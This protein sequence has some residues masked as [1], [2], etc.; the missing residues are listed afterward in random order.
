M[1]VHSF[2]FYLVPR[3]T[4]GVFFFLLLTSKGVI[5]VLSFLRKK[6]E[7]KPTSSSNCQK[8]VFV[9]SVCFLFCPC[10]LILDRVFYFINFPFHIFSNSYSESVTFVFSVL[11]IKERD[12]N[13]CL[14]LVPRHLV[15]SKS[16]LLL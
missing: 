6:I 16:Q 8:L 3:F 11:L 12:I 13:K 7:T 2:C 4:S 1:F 14:Y 10:Q 5:F 15:Y 9:H